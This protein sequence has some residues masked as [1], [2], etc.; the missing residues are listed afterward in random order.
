MP[1]SRPSTTKGNLT[2]LGFQE[3]E[4]SLE[5][6]ALI[7]GAAEPLL[8]FLART[9]DPDLALASLVRL[10]EAAGRQSGETE[11]GQLLAALVDDEGTA[12]R[13]L[14]VL[15]ASEALADHLCRHPEHWRELT[16]PTMGSTRPAAY[17]V[18]EDL[19]R[20]VGAE[21]SDAEPVATRP[22]AEAV[23]ALRVEYRRILLRLASRDLTHH[24]GVDDA[25]AELS[26]LA[27]G[28]LD[29]ALAIARQRVALSMG[30]SQA[31]V[32]RLAVV[33]M[34]K[35]GGHE[36]NYVSDVDVIFV[37]EAAEGAD[38]SSAQQSEA[39][40]VAT[41]LAS[42]LMRVCSE[43]TGEGTIWP[44][45]AALRPEGKAGPLTRTLASHQGYYERWASTWEFQALL[46][47]RAVAGDLDLG[48][49]YVAMVQPMVWGAAGRDGFVEDTQAM[50]R[51]VIDHIP[52][53]Q[54]ERQ[55]K[56]GSGGLRDVEFAVQLL[57]LVHGRADESIRQPTT[58]SALAE[59]ARHGY[60]GREDGDTL[61]DAYA[62]LRTL[63][64]RIQLFQLRRTHVVPE[65]ERALRR[66][67]RSLGYVKEPVAT[68]D[69]EWQH[70]RREVRRLHE[71]LFYRP[72]L[73]AVA[74]L[75]TDEARLTPE[76]AT[77]R[78]A[79]LGF[80][81]PAAALRHL[82]ALTSGV[83][84]TANIQRQLLPAML[85][86]FADA[87]D[88]DAGLF[89]FRRLSES[90]GRTPWYLKTLRDEGQV[91]ERLARLLATSRFVSDL[92]EKEPAGVRMLGEDLTPLEAEPIVEEMLSA[93]GRREDPEAAVR[94]IRAVRRRELL[95]V[96]AGDS[97]GQTDVADVGAALSRITDATLEA[98]LR[99][100]LAS[101]AQA[102]KV[103]SP[104][105]RMAVI[106][107]GRYGG[108]E[109]SYGSDADVL[110]VHEAAD[111]VDQHEASSYAIAVANELRRLLA[112]P[113]GDPALEVDADLRPEGKQGPLS[114][115][116]ESHAAYYAKWS[117][118]WEAQALLRADAV[119]GDERLRHRFVEL[120]DPL[121]YP[122]V[123]L[124][125]DDVVEVRRIKA[126]VD[127]ERLPRG[128]DPNSHLKLGRGGLADIEWTVQLLQMQHA[129]AVP[130]LR[131]SRTL[132]ALEAARAAGLLS[133]SDADVLVSGWRWVSRVR[134]AITLVRGKGSDQL[135]H[136]IRERAAVANVLG[137]PAAA[138]DQMVNDH[139]RTM[140]VS[141]DVVD[142]VFWG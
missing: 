130:G 81:D 122:A 109:L 17:A 69:K 52:A 132:E 67:G 68:L 36:L 63:E 105:A 21:P 114:R 103:A 12:M 1:D 72:L 92:L 96:A 29:A 48:K 7:G 25:A 75:D 13:L 46:K 56:L 131:T 121:R 113:G 141:H 90:L 66:L 88:P 94:A 73:T 83:T 28:T 86:W 133:A 112:L 107:M 44:V 127:Q 55:L 30:Q 95:R 27:A 106:A 126:R 61:H 123:G 91:A 50:R 57:Q 124:S 125:G 118:V 24:L 33:A 99:V 9:A 4:Q 116:L 40:R 77:Q 20:A 71:K 111:G 5:N 59:L 85:D 101:V 78:L 60:V 58:L 8:A 100:V 11:A 34:G 137:Y 22:D 134:N 136:D 19:L 37:H 84:R 62:F 23:D 39:L 41:Q 139:L 138:T 110:F 10:V 93:A 120:I 79:A 38:A 74:R 3:P 80:A 70:H 16:D 31:H 102:K 128:A 15:G 2:R 142:R 35:C 18:R 82:E 53:N 6:L 32:A 51:R 54:A 135:P 47:A 97:L 87:P 49:R 98:T 119:V 129:Q 65:D 140:R 14:S 89:G 115:S 117:K 104:P 45:D 43:Q 76:A 64:H 42:H 26:D 108:F